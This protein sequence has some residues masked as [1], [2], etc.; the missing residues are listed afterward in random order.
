M[1]QGRDAVDRVPGREGRRGG[2][3]ERRLGPAAVADPPRPRL[4]ALTGEDDERQVAGAAVV[5]PVPAGQLYLGGVDLLHVGDQRL[6]EVPW[7]SPTAEHERVHR[8][9]P[10]YQRGALGVGDDPLHLAEGRLPGSVAVGSQ[11]H[12]D[13]PH[14]AERYDDG[15]GAGTSSHQHPD[16]LALANADRDQPADYVVDPLIDLDGAVGAV[17]EQEEGV[18]WCPAHAL[19]DQQTERDPRAWLD[20]LQ[21]R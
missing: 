2:G 9:Q 15:Q 12:R 10:G 19:V 20:L 14:P 6:A 4:L 13:R 3:P 7:T 11:Q 21:A 1:I 18:V 8:S 5:G 16:M 17:L